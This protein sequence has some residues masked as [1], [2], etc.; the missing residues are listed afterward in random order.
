MPACSARAPAPSVISPR[1]NLATV[2]IILAVL[3]DTWVQADVNIDLLHTS[4][5]RKTKKGNQDDT[6]SR[7][8]GGVGLPGG[9]RGELRSVM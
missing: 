7:G 8:G 5:E 9:N 6:E 1:E 2:A 3:A 4:R